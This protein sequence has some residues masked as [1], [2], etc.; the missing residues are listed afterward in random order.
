MP[1][2]ASGA[3]NAGYASE[4][5]MTNTTLKVSYIGYNFQG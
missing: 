1:P 3:L 2:E 5:A 4:Y